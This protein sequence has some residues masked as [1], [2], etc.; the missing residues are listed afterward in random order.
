MAK[1]QSKADLKAKK[2]AQAA[3]F[4]ESPQLW[5]YQQGIKPGCIIWGIHPGCPDGQYL[6]LKAHPFLLMGWGPEG[7]GL[8]L[9]LS[10]SKALSGSFFGQALQPANGMAISAPS[11]DCMLMAPIQLFWA[12]GKDAQAEFSNKHGFKQAFHFRLKELEAA[13]GKGICKI[14]DGAPL[15]PSLIGP[16]SKAAFAAG[17]FKIKSGKQ[18]ALHQKPGCQK[19]AIC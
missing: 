6:D 10:S 2:L 3:L 1:S 16:M 14:W 5:A 4:T 18:I 7:F 17:S 9:P 15:A 13:K 11:W 8:L 12:M 19:L